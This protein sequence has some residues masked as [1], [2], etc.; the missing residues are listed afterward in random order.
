MEASTAQADVIP[1]RAHRMTSPDISML[2][3]T[4]LLSVTSEEHSWVFA[5]TDGSALRCECPWRLVSDDRI[6]V[7]SDDHDQRFGLARTIDAGARAA[8]RVAERPVS[9]VSIAVDTGDLTLRFGPSAR[10]EVLVNSSG[11]ES[12]HLSLSDGRMVVATGGGEIAHSRG[13]V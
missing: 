13:A 11:Y 2:A 5:F 1:T 9:A 10:I 4:S 6:A 3:G 7:T 8:E 12:W